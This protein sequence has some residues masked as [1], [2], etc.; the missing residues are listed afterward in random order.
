MIKPKDFLLLSPHAMY[1]NKRIPP[2]VVKTLLYLFE[3][4]MKNLIERE[5]FQT[6]V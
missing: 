1:I 3:M 5:Y 2:M 6:F 4:Q